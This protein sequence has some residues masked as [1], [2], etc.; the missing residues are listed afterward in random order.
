MLVTKEDRKKKKAEKKKNDK[1]NAK[2]TMHE[3]NVNVR[4][5]MIHI[6]GDFI[7]SIGVVIAAIVIYIKPEYSLADPICTFLFS[8]LVMLTT[9]NVVKDCVRVLME[10]SPKGVNVEKLI[11]DIEKVR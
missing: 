7:Q 3:E 4:A 6:I 1:L 8:I 10:A 5:A 2:S 11:N 9:V